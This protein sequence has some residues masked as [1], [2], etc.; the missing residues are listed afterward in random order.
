M[1]GVCLSPSSLLMEAQILFR[2]SMHSGESKLAHAIM[3]T[4]LPF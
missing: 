1:L 3:L 2:Y 4:S